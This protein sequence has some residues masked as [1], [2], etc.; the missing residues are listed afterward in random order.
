MKLSG[1]KLFS[2]TYFQKSFLQLLMH[3]IAKEHFHSAKAL[4]FGK[5]IN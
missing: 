5:Y 4:A 2:K 3:K 1:A